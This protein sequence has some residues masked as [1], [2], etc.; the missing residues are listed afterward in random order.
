MPTNS[1][2]KH[3]ELNLVVLNHQSAN[4]NQSSKWLEVGR[5]IEQSA[6]YQR[7]LVIQ[8]SDTD[9]V[10]AQMSIWQAEHHPLANQLAFQPHSLEKTIVI[11]D[12]E[13]VE[14]LGDEPILPGALYLALREGRIMKRHNVLLFL[15]E[16][17]SHIADLLKLKPLKHLSPITDGTVERRAYAQL[18]DDAMYHVYKACQ[19]RIL[20]LV[21]DE[22]TNEIVRTFEFWLRELY[23]GPWAR[24]IYERT[25]TREQYVS[26]LSNFHCFVRY[27]TRLLG[28][29][30]AL[31][32]DQPLRDHYIQH[33]K[34]EIN[35][36][37]IIERDLEFLQED[38]EYVKQYRQP[39]YETKAFLVV[40]ESTLA[41]YQ[42]PVLFLACPIAAEGVAA[43]LTQEFLDCLYA[44]IAS[45]GI[46]EPKKAAH[47]ITS[48][49]NFDGGDDGHWNQT[50]MKIKSY[51]Q[52]E[53][54]VRE[55]LGV[56]KTAMNALERSYNA[57][58]ED[59]RLWEPLRATKTSTMQPVS[60][61]IQRFA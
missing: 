1:D 22:M 5:R 60:Q 52:T 56:L 42:D 33:L 35:H 12:I 3:T 4:I 48:H 8:S 6:A 49:T 34:G 47:F 9:R 41:Y 36:E 40:Q 14:K 43:Y 38:V 19:D 2:T 29:A 28:R 24:A 50:I 46:K 11:S 32:N 21:Q 57:N 25:L 31:S 55:F 18:I 58:I 59:L 53:T 10:F 45:W 26:T 23:L 30:I 13:I 61:P 27:T 15:S 54:R 39:S 16:S 17:E 7:R 44:C 37:K 51:V 20:H